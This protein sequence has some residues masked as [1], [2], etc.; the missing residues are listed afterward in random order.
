MWNKIKTYAA[1]HPLI[2]AFS[3]FL[4]L[5]TIGSLFI[6]GFAIT[7]MIVGIIGMIILA[8]YGTC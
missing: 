5:F 6:N 7:F 3:I 4:G 2:A 8:L 1:E